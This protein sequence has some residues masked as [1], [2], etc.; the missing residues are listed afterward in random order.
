MI[1][2]DSDILIDFFRG[3]PASRAWFESLDLV[4]IAIPGFVALELYAGCRNKAEQLEIRRK[5]DPYT[6]LWPSGDSSDDIIPIFA[7]GHLTHAL[8]IIDSLIAATALSHNL[9]LHTFNQKHFAAV[10]NLQ[11]IQ[12]YVR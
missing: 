4:Q 7:S 11:I 6:V 1:L 10:P 9:P 8:G 3:Q 12:P 5:L 2:L